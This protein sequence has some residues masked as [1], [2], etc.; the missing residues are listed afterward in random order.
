[1]FHKAA[2]A[3][4]QVLS[5]VDFETYEASL[6]IRSAVERQFE[7]IGEALA[8]LAR[9]DPIMAAKIEDVGQI[10]AFRNLLIHGYATVEHGRVW[11]IAREALPPLKAAVESL[12]EDANR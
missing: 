2:V 7:I 12:L 4:F 5:G 10:I 3:I 6:L 8:A 11:R 9:H 1:M